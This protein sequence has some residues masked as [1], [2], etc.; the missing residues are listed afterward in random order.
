MHQKAFGGRR[1]RRGKGEEGDGRIGE[2]EK[3]RGRERSDRVGG[4]VE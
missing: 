1:R 2:R 4:E 3:G